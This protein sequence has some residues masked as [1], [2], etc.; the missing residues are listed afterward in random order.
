LLTLCPTPPSSGAVVTSTSAIDFSAQQPTYSHRPTLVANAEERL[1]IALARR[2]DFPLAIAESSSSRRPPR[3]RSPRV[4]SQDSLS[5][6][7]ER[8]RESD[9]VSECTMS[10]ERQPSAS[11]FRPK[12]MKADELDEVIA[13]VQADEV[14]FRLSLL[15]MGHPSEFA[16]RY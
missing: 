16:F 8:R 9:P 4:D 14:G 12:Q 13:K 7:W 1:E 5:S 11:F 3:L 6:S 2:A 15:L 10:G